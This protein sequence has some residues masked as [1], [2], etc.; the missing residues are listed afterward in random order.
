MPAND[1]AVRKHAQMDLFQNPEWE[2]GPEELLVGLDADA[3]RLARRQEFLDAFWF[4][5]IRSL[6]PGAPDMCSS[7]PT[8]VARY[9]SQTKVLD[10]VSSSLR[11]ALLLRRC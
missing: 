11:Y 10:G 3:Q 7:L 2:E 8:I 5:T 1:L 6:L 4:L 9:M